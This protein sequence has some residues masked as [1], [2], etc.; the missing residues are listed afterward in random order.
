M[1]INLRLLGVLIIIIIPLL[2][3][4]NWEIV[5][6]TPEGWLNRANAELST[7][8]TNAEYDISTV[9]T[10]IQGAQKDLKRDERKQRQRVQIFLLANSVIGI[11]LI[12]MSFRKS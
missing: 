10:C 8:K 11:T 7:G 9:R 1:K 3:M 6:S 4:L 5:K 12:V 2:D